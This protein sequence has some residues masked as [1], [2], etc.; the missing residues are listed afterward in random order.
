MTTTVEYAQLSSRVY[1]AS[2]DN[3][4]GVPTNWSELSWR[5]D[6]L[7]IGFSAGVYKNNT[8]NQIVIAYTGTN[9]LV[10]DWVANLANGVGIASSQVVT[11]MKLYLDVK[12]ANPGAALIQNTIPSREV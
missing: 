4:T 1:A 8:T 9:N 11:A 3:R 12:K 2:R 7:L 6:S 5:P 10:G